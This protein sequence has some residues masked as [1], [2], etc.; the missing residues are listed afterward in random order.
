[1]IW[2]SNLV[3]LLQYHVYSRNASCA[4]SYISTLLFKLRYKKWQSSY[5]P[6][7]T[8][9]ENLFFT[10]YKMFESD[11]RYTN[12]CLFYY[13]SIQIKDTR[14]VNYIEQNVKKDRISARRRNRRCLFCTWEYKIAFVY[15]FLT[16]RDQ[17]NI[18]T[19]SVKINLICTRSRIQ[20]RLSTCC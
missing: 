18:F 13:F 5:V 10:N 3:T 2:L 20:A 4:L 9:F 16:V 1:M 19:F 11:K 7:T 14:C 6:F 12:A 17:H 15:D 8:K